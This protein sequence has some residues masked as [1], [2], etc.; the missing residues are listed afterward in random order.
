MTKISKLNPTDWKKYKK[1]RLEALKNEPTAF[2]A[3]YDEKR[4]EPDSYWINKM[5]DVNDTILIEEMDNKVVGLVRVT[6][7]D[8]EIPPEYAYVGS[9]YINKEYR[10][11]GISKKLM[12]AAEN[13]VKQETSL[14]GIFLEVYKSQESAIMLY[15]KLGYKIIEKRVKDGVEDLV[16]VKDL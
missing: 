5:N 8:K 4:L 9:L 3:S 10:G 6:V 1:I 14:K 12:S 15:N 11:L 7:N 13:Y 2:W 16:M